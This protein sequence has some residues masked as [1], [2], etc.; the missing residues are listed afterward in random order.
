[1]LRR[2]EGRCSAQP[3]VTTV[4]DTLPSSCGQ[5]SC[6][7]AQAREQPDSCQL[8]ALPGHLYRTPIHIQHSHCHPPVFRQQSSLDNINTKYD[9]TYMICG[10]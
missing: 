5:G 1:M 2:V 8:R 4:E 7:P 3:P 6:R 9:M 10:N